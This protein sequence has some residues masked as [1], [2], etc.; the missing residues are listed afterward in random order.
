MP[1]QPRSRKAAAPDPVPVEV[2]DAEAEVPLPD[3]EV[4]AAEAQPPSDWFDRL[5]RPGADPFG[6]VRR[7]ATKPAARLN[8]EAPLVTCDID[9]A[10]AWEV[11]LHDPGE[12]LPESVG[13]IHI[14]AGLREFIRHFYASMP[15]EGDRPAQFLLHPVNTLGQRLN[16]GAP[17]QTFR[18]SSNHTVL[19]EMRAA[20]ISPETPGRSGGGGELSAVIE[21][22]REQAAAERLRAEAAE[23]RA[24]AERARADAERNALL[25]QRIGQSTI[26]ATD[27]SDAYRAVGEAQRR[28]HEEALKASTTGM[29]DILK[30]QAETAT[31]ERERKAQERAEERERERLAREEERERARL[32]REEERERRREEAAAERERLRQEGETRRAEINAQ[33]EKARIDAQAERERLDRERDRE[34]ARRDAERLREE[35]R[36]ERER[37]RERA[38][39]AAL[40]TLRQE[41]L[42]R[43]LSRTSA[44]D[45]RRREH[46]NL[47]LATIKE[48][49]AAEGGA[50][51]LGILSGVLK[52]FGMT[53]AEALLKGKELFDS[54]AGGGGGIGV[55]IVKGL[56]ELATKV[57]E[58]IG[59]AAAE[60]DDEEEEEESEE[61]EKR[62]RPPKKKPEID[63]NKLGKNPP[64]DAV[65]TRA[66]PDPRATV[67]QPVIESKA[68]LELVRVGRGLFGDLVDQ[69]E[70][71][72]FS[73]WGSVIMAGDSAGLVT[74]ANK[75]GLIAACEGLDIDVGM[76][77]KALSDLGMPVPMRV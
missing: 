71:K 22:L 27:M 56:T 9:D 6:P 63:I 49:Q 24:E 68:D 59:N 66:L 50:G 26:I 48:R 5:N 33:I 43:E 55:E 4:P 15:K 64:A 58:T 14:N 29:G 30:F 77:G 51:S 65:E 35:A 73:E 39:L 31:A 54:F 61:P 44:D 75:V 40:E 37:D 19:R 36:Q 21:L 41:A 74:F 3:R 52:E 57:V 23:K 25:E 8:I 2:E 42:E 12:P 16:P 38:H 20:G 46:F 60:E 62:E 18:V 7:D 11:E 1:S 53:P 45:D 10:S 69:I 17:Y 47:M 32:D 34:D 13:L 70:D 76:L 28:A 67:E 72:G